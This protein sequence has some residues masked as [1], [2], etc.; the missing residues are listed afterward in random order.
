MK[1]RLAG[2]D[3]L[4][5]EEEQNHQVVRKELAKLKK[6]EGAVNKVRQL[7]LAA[8]VDYLYQLFSSTS[9]QQPKKASVSATT[10]SAVMVQS[11]QHL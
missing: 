5:K 2:Q 6:K 9:L 10:V 1:A 4:L 11:W 7:S 8:A 3:L